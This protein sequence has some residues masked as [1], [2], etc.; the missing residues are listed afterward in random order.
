MG[1][2][3]TGGIILA[4]GMSKRFGK[5]K[6]LHELGGSTILSMVIDASIKSDLDVIVLVLGH[7][8]EAIKA[9]L[10]SRLIEPRLTTV[11]NPDYALG[12]STSLQR[13]LT[14]VK[15]RVPSIMV[16]MGDQPLISHE[17]INRILQAFRSAGKDICIPVFKGKNMQPVCI[18]SR[19]YD[20]IFNVTGDMGARK[21]IRDNPDAILSLEMDE[22]DGFIDIDSKEDLEIFKIKTD[23]F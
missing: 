17:T 20:E 23:N 14:E 4:A 5:T 1:K 9:S 10:G 11:I 22:E 13:G 18:S 21:V 2:G 8:S 6:Q 12:M 16:L 3:P 7:E 19:F 15:D